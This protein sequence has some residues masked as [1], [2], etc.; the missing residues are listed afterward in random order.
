MFSKNV[1]PCTPCL[2]CNKTELDQLHLHFNSSDE[3]FWVYQTT[4]V[5]CCDR[6]RPTVSTERWASIASGVGIASSALLATQSNFTTAAATLCVSA[7]LPTIVK[8][9]DLDH[10]VVQ[11]PIPIDTVGT[12]ER[13]VQASCIASKGSDYRA[14]GTFISHLQLLD[15]S[16][17]RKQS[18][19]AW[20]P[21][22][23]IDFTTRARGAS[24]QYRRGH[25]YRE[26]TAPTQAPSD[27]VTSI[28]ALCSVAPNADS[29]D[30]M[31]GTNV[32][33]DAYGPEERVKGV[34]YQVEPKILAHQIG[35]DLIPTE[36]MESSCSNLK[37][38]LAK[39][40]KP[41]GYKANADTSA[42]IERTVNALLKEVFSKEKIREWRQN[43]PDIDEFK[44]SK[45]DSSRWT[46]AVD[47]ALAD[48]NAQIEQTFQIKVNEALPAKDKAPRPIIQCG[49]RAQAMMNLPVKCFEDLMFDYFEDASIK[50]IDK[51]GAMKR[52]AS[53]L[54]QDKV[55]A[56]L[57][58]GDGSAWDSCCNPKIR[59]MTENRIIRHIITALGDDPQVPKAWMQKTL[60]DM[61]KKYIKGKAGVSDFCVTPLKVLIESIRQSGHR[62]TSCFNYLINLV[63]WLVVLCDKP[64]AMIKKCKDGSLRAWYKSP[65]DGKCY[66]L[67]Y[68][69][70][71][72]DS[73]ISTTEDLEKYAK[74]IE[75]IWTNLGFRMKLI[76]VKE[77][78]T[79]T[80]YDFLVDDHGPT[81][82]MVP[83]ICRNIASSSWTCSSIVKSDPRR[84]FEVGMNAMLARA[85]NFKECG[86][87]SKYFAS[88]GLAHAKRCGDMAL[89]LDAAKSLG[90]HTSDSVVSDL[91][92]LY[93]SAEVMSEDMRRLV[94][95]VV[96]FSKEQELR[97]LTVDFQDPF[98]LQQAR[99]VVPSSIWDPKKYSRPR[100]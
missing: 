25:L 70:E 93:L 22:A 10:Q 77:K 95:L 8:H 44:S 21:K 69:F 73:A 20:A 89:D 4:A 100:R 16:E 92:D 27:D 72:D 85:V 66:T 98:D 79:F 23:M 86:P 41:L 35:P 3:E 60:A 13:A 29:V 11:V 62:G 34:S 97:M 82:V 51:L 6:C 57:I 56:K 19:C 88:L 50:H 84:K 2:K 30:G 67:R 32:E 12:I 39:R 61:D 17:I 45:W 54:R 28:A 48:V 58:E 83:E 7:G 53:H 78:M 38:G 37:A 24:R 52:V 64:E 33:A 14:H 1:G 65:R 43:N 71:G 74:E 99:M 91:Q 47:E 5:R 46:Q 96:P 81:G 9:L 36:V 68:A 18:L 87:I 55:A 76:Y 31:V 63:C 94:N 80:G 40:V 42:K 49:D 75:Q 15:T 90:I 59:A 26:P